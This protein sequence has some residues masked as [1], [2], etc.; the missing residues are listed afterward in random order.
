MA[1][2]VGEGFRV[3]DLAASATCVLVGLTLALKTTPLVLAAGQSPQ[4]KREAVSVNVVIETMLV[5]PDGT[6]GP[7]AVLSR[8]HVKSI[9]GPGRP[10]YEVTVLESAGR[11]ALDL[12]KINIDTHYVIDG[13]LDNVEA[14]GEGGISL[15]KFRS[16]GLMK[17]QPP[18][19]AVSP[20]TGS[21]LLSASRAVRHEDAKKH[22]GTRWGNVGSRERYVEIEDN[23]AKETLIDP[24][25]G[26]PVEVNVIRNGRLAS[27]LTF[28]YGALSDGRVH[29]SEVVAEQSS[30]QW[31]GYRIVTRTKYSGWHVSRE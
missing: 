31:P 4:Q 20:P 11:T 3:R 12:E 13:G 14:T 19:I 10:R 18:G 16:R 1:Q 25:N 8:H 6:I 22:V 5:S 24:A 2:K 26:L 17:R 29:V 23:G 9:T 28:E 21:L 15:H 30:D 7:S 27:H